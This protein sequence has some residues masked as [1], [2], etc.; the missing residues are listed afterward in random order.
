RQRES[1]YNGRFVIPN[2]NVSKFV[3]K[4]YKDKTKKDNNDSICG[5]T[6]PAAQNVSRKMAKLDESGLEVATCRHVLAQKA[7]NMFRGEIFGYPYFLIK[8]FMIPRGTNFCFAD[9]MCKLWPFMTRDDPSIK[10]LISPALSIM[11]AKGHSHDCQ[12]IWSGEWLKGTGRSTGEETEQLFNYLSRF[13]NS[14]KYQLPE[15]REETLTE[16]VLHWNKVK[17]KKIVPDLAKR[18]RKV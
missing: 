8:E 9:V 6:W 1:F 5:G 18:Y 13:G 16:A 7:I 3:E 4:L 14:T 2:E 11:H 15:K 17:V 12:L 10:T